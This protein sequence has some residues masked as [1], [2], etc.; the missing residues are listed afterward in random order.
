MKAIKNYIAFMM[1]ATLMAVS[2]QE[3]DGPETKDDPTF[4]QLV[5]N[6]NVQA[7]EILTLTFIPNY[8][9][10]ISIP[11]ELRQ[12]FW[13][14]DGSFSVSELSGYATNNPVQ[15]RIGVSQV[16]EFDRNFSCDVTLTM[17][18]KSE[19]IAK[20]MLPAKERTLEVASEQMTSDVI[21][22]AWS[23][24]DADFRALV[25]VTSNT[26]WTVETPEW[27]YV[28]VPETTLG[29]VDLVFTGESL[30]DASGKVV[31]KTGDTV[32]KEVQVSVPSCADFVIY[33]AKMS[34]GEFEYGEE[35]EY[36]WT[37]EPVS[38]INMAWLGAD[39][40]MP[41]H[42]DSKCN[43]TVELPEWLKVELP[44]ATA[45]IVSATLLGVPSKYPLNDTEG[46]IVFK[47]GD[48][49]ISEIGVFMPGCQ[50]IM[51]FIVSMSLTEL[52]YNYIGEV[53]TS[54][55]YVSSLATATLEGVKGVR[56][57][58]VE[59]TGGSVGSE[60]PAWFTYEMTPW[61]NSTD[62]PVMQDR[63]FTFKVTENTGDARSAVLFT[64]PPSV[65]A[66]TADL[67]NADA[68]VKSEYEKY[69]LNVRQASM[70]Y[71]NY[72]SVNVN[73]S[74]EFA[75]TFEKAEAQ[76]AE[77][78]TAV[79]GATEH[80]YT[81]SYESPYSRDEAFMTMT[82]PFSSYKV[83]S[84]DDL[85]TDRSHEEGFWLSFMNAGETNNYGVVDMYSNEMPLP[86]ELSVGYVVFYNASNEVLAIVE[87]ISPV[88][89]EE[90]L[91]EIPEGA[92]EDEDGD[93]VE[94]ADIYFADKAAALNAKATLVRVLETTDKTTKEEMS[95]GA[96]VLKL[97]VPADTPVEI[98]L[99]EACKYYQMPY[100]LSSYISV[101]GEAYSET[102]GMLDTAI[103]TASISMA[104]HDPIKNTKDFVKFHTSMSE[105]YPFMVVY[106]R[107]R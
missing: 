38:K 30:T 12:W 21:A 100:A 103:T 77:Q 54:T 41:I 32:L 73:P 74:A 96:I 63:S 86:S 65:T 37:D 62:A 27:L 10:T 75:Y 55:G 59:T 91:P 104:A 61:D 34:E 50:D 3:K 106:I 71:D 22:L 31:F 9:W 7:G 43:W 70:H 44:D 90:V 57:F 107:L 35:G 48:T 97:T 29:V 49:I 95:E 24:D 16:Q 5:E 19:V 80:V 93:T 99:S 15:V 17:D 105:T 64:L 98:A 69:A 6:Y 58:A 52:E 83:F 82:I 23:A 84:A 20:Y 36:A 11:T 1:L 2:C 79:F 89:E 60:N 40:R 39:F 53:N 51:S 85:A 78:L 68:S 81:L 87:C 92:F 72:I 46:K 28:N 14:I 42:I 66:V 76:K 67:F 26:E 56:V 45:G 88:K 47:L 13:I 101:N 8:N 4:P 102:M 25:Q 33:T 18:G 94:N